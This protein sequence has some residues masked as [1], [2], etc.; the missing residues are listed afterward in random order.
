MLRGKSRLRIVVLHEIAN[1]G[2]SGLAG[3]IPAG[4]VLQA[5]MPAGFLTNS[6]TIFS[7][8]SRATSW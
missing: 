2:P 7:F 4:G 1:L 5:E 3:P 6:K 8:N